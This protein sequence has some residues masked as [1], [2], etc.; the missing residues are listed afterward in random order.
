ML[1]IC[2]HIEYL[3]TEHDCVLIPE[4]GGFVLQDVPARRS[5]DGK[6]W[7]PPTRAIVFNPSL[8][9]NDGMLVSSLMRARK[10]DAHHALLLIR[11]E[12]GTLRSLLQKEGDCVAFGE[13]GSFVL[14]ENLRPAFTANAG[15]RIDLRQF[16]MQRL[17]V[18][19]LRELSA[20]TAQGTK[21]VDTATDKDD[22]IHISIHRRTIYKIAA[23]AAVFLL[24]FLTASPIGEINRTENLATL[25]PTEVVQ[26]D[27]NNRIA[28]P[29]YLIVVS[30]LS[31][32]ENALLQ[33]QRFH[34]KGVTEMMFL[35]EDGRRVYLYTRTFADRQEAYSYVRQQRQA[36]TPF[37]DAWVMKAQPTK[38]K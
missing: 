29:E 28:K 35:Y 25:T 34:N 1:E 8:T 12:V 9:Y 15:Y 10:T 36:G 5:D 30:T 19:P 4:W 37:A 33:L 32:R 6:T 20:P 23:A 7:F 2:R 24:L 16:G 3:L 26:D 11:Q 13:M 31:T 27:M 18:L 17:T 14:D 22:T 38:E 21:T